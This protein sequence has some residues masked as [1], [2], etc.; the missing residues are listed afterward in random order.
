M[1]PKVQ[2]LEARIRELDRA[3][4]HEKKR[5]MESHKQICRRDRRIKELTLEAEEYKQKVKDVQVTVQDLENE[6]RIY[7]RRLDDSQDISHQNANRYRKAQQK[8]QDEVIK[9]EQYEEKVRR[10]RAE[11]QQ[12]P[13][14]VQI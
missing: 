8:Y 13:L 7:K 9:I 2:A 5:S 11:Q 6:I 4:D 12:T 1:D 14:F 3:L 10:R